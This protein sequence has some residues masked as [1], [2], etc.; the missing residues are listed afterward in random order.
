MCCSPWRHRVV[1]D[2]ATKQQQQIPYWSFYLKLFSSHSVDCLRFVNDFL[3]CTKVLSSIGSHCLFLFLFLY[4]RKWNLD[5]W[6]NMRHFYWFDND[7]VKSK[8][9]EKIGENLDS[10]QKVIK[11]L[12]FV[13]FKNVNISGKKPQILVFRKGNSGK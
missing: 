13:V 5:F 8:M 12:L 9:R 1:H 6:V 2:L 3:Y 4:L 7:C 11:T 10:W